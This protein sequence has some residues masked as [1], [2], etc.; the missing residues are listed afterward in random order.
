MGKP[1]KKKKPVYKILVGKPAPLRG[2]SP[3]RKIIIVD[4]MDM[5][6]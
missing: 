3:N 4:E 2:Y 1:K 5:A 6:C